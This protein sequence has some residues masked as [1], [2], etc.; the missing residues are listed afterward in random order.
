MRFNFDN[1]I[2]NKPLNGDKIFHLPPNND[3]VSCFIEG[4]L[5]R[6]QDGALKSNPE[7]LGQVLILT[8]N[9]SLANQIESRLENSVFRNWPE[10]NTR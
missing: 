7:L 6:F 2:I 10:V 5:M 8:A 9:K 4:F 3:F 1:T